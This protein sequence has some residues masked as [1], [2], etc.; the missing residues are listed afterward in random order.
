M[1]DWNMQENIKNQLLEAFRRTLYDLLRVASHCKN[2]AFA[3]EQEWRLSLPIP[4]RRAPTNDTILYR[5]ASG[6]V[7]YIAS[8][9]FRPDNRL[10]ITR[11]MTGPQCA[12]VDEV[13][14]ILMRSG[15]SL[16]IVPSSIPLRDT[17]K[18]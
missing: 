3:E 4:T 14:E 10:P 18:L 12:N 17:S 9:L 8:N 13:A 16:P 11:V 5:G 6:K 15:Y 7:P 2:P 1:F